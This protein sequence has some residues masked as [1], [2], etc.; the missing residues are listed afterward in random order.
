MTEPEKSVIFV[1]ITDDMGRSYAE[2]L[3]EYAATIYTDQ[4]IYR[5][6]IE[7]TFDTSFPEG[8]INKYYKGQPVDEQEKW[9]KLKEQKEFRKRCKRGR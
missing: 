1:T 2:A 8:P 7:E 4:A 6:S 9:R 3:K 5:I